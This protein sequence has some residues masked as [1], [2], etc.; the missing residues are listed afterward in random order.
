MNLWD[1]VGPFRGKASELAA[2]FG[3]SFDARLTPDMERQAKEF[4]REA[5]SSHYKSAGT[6]FEVIFL[7]A[8][9]AGVMHRCGL[10]LRSSEEIEAERIGDETS[11]RK[12]R[13]RKKLEEERERSQR[14]KEAGLLELIHHPEVVRFAS[15]VGLRFG[16][17]GGCSADGRTNFGA[18]LHENGL[19]TRKQVLAFCHRQISLAGN[20]FH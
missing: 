11:E 3:D 9:R 18:F 6:G 13:A 5:V 1:Y 14:K 12:R 8:C 16:G 2:R 10:N 4:C 15:E 7:R 19:Q 17:N 20:G